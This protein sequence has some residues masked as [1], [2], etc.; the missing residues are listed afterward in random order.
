M[1]TLADALPKE[2]ERITQKRDR[3]IKMA[4]EHPKMAAGMNVT[5]ALMQHEIMQAVK[6]S[7]EG[8]VA[9]MAASLESLRAYSHDD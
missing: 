6:A 2:I 5:I 4:A 3:W 8:D 1:E 7:A 9:R